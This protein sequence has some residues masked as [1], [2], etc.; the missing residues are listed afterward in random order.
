MWK[1]KIVRHGEEKVE[2]L[3][4][5]EWNWRIHP[6]K[7]QEA[8]KG[9]LEEIGVIQTVIVNL[10]TSSEWGEDQRVETMLDGHARVKL[11]MRHGQET[12]PVTYV[13]L[14]PKEE[15]KAL[16]AFDRITQMANED[17]VMLF[18][19]I[20]SITQNGDEFIPTI[21]E[22]EMQRISSIVG[23]NYTPEIGDSEYNQDD[24]DKAQH[25]LDNNVGLGHDYIEVM[26]PNCA[27]EF[28]IRRDEVGL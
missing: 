18:D 14:T 6:E 5:N 19:L 22:S 24:I 1:N 13:D 2:S 11:A 16:I 9:S 15:K 8:L 27:N 23:R 7:Q 12:L 21:D 26:C 25:D 3:L 4:A 10:R 28:F 17:S 20:D